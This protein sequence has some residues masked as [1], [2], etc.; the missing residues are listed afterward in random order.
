[1]S[2]DLVKSK[3][4]RFR[5]SITLAITGDVKEQENILVTGTKEMESGGCVTSVTM[6][7]NGATAVK[8]ATTF[9]KTVAEGGSERLRESLGHYF[10]NY[11][12]VVHVKIM[13]TPRV[14]AGNTASEKAL[15][16]TK[17]IDATN[18]AMYGVGESEYFF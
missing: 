3:N 16:R 4:R 5:P 10:H 12:D 11:A 2:C 6:K 17:H 13:Q 7:V 1:M 15:E 9:A 8:D 14:L 18:A